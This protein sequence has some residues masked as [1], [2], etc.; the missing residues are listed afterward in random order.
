MG[1]EKTEKERERSF[2]KEEEEKVR[3][4]LPREWSTAD[5]SS[6]DVCVE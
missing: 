1:T 6:I 5:H 3:S 2:L 4:D